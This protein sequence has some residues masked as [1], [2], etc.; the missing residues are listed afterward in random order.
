MSHESSRHMTDPADR[1]NADAGA[2]MG[3]AAPT[4]RRR[5]IDCGGNAEITDRRQQGRGYRAAP[6][7][8]Q[9]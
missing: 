2:P 1:R 5:K 9:R 6:L 7:P 3:V 4:P 8:D